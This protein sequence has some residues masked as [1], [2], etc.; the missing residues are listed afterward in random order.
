M[1]MYVFYKINNYF[2]FL[3]NNIT[4]PTHQSELDTKYKFFPEDTFNAFSNKHVY[5]GGQINKALKFDILK[6]EEEYLVC[7]SSYDHEYIRILKIEPAKSIF[8]WRASIDTTSIDTICEKSEDAAI[9]HVTKF[10][11]FHKNLLL[12]RIL[13]QK[14]NV[15]TCT[16][17]FRKYC[18]F[19]SYVLWV[20]NP[21][22]D[23]FCHL[24]STF[25]V[26]KE[27]INRRDN[28]SLH[29]FLNSENGFEKRAPKRDCI[30][31]SVAQTMRTLNRV[32]LD[33]G[34]KE[35][36]GVLDLFS[37]LHEFYLREDTRI[38]IKNIIEAK[39]VEHT[40]Y[41]EVS[42]HNIEEYFSKY[43]PGDLSHFLYGLSKA[44][45]REL[46]F[47]ACSV[48]EKID[49]KNAL[50]LVA[51]NDAGKKTL[52]E[53][54]MEYDLD[55]KSF[56]GSVFLSGRWD[57]SYDISKDPRNSHTYD[58]QTDVAG[59][60]W[61]AFTL[62]LDNKKWGILRVKNKYEGSESRNL[63]N[64]ST[65]DYVVLRSVCTHLSNIFLLEKEYK[66]YK[67]Q[68]LQLQNKE[69]SLE[70][71]LDELQ[72]FYNVFLHEIKTPISTFSTSPLRISKMLSTLNIDDEVKESI[73]KKVGDIK[74]MGE[75]LAFI[76]NKY[77]FN[78]LVKSGKP[79]RLS[80]L[81]DIIHPVL[82]IS[83]EYIQTQY[84]VDISFDSET[85]GGYFV[86]GDKILLN[87]VFNTIISN[88]GKYSAGS[89]RPITIVGEI[90]R[91][92]DYFN[93]CVSN[94]GFS[95]YENEKERVF[96]NRVR[97]RQAEKEKIGGTGIGLYLARK[98]MLNQHGNVLLTSLSNPVTFKIQLSLKWKGDIQK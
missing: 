2:I 4:T 93:I 80:V 72:N 68:L 21:Y 61:M 19:D 65:K 33:L 18:F 27:Y 38:M 50:K 59:K 75:R 8:N 12:K 70:K 48:F 83:K 76:A 49:G 92:L 6:H 15:I 40:K 47:M 22:T 25:P 30:N 71:D 41:S 56:T 39:Y 78:E 11:L 24:A 34:K 10:K 69:K 62:Q 17:A 43:Q 36:I 95:I 91:D 28:S 3:E 1:D 63:I 87:I 60:S 46:H 13:G 96:E 90:T 29:D 7:K 37:V 16:E 86:Y 53:K 77:Y 20:Y 55:Q 88:A 74:I 94:Y 9:A 58:E 73:N 79:E 89:R 26:S 44:I 35:E 81:A 85:I 42:L 57:F 64:F 23:H 31:S 45:C 66:E 97:G 32:R 82:N 98:I 54:V 52:S 67:K 51:T 14:S 5:N 84:K